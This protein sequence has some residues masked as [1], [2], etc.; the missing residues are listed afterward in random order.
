MKSKTVK[1][2][3]AGQSAETEQKSV[4]KLSLS[5]HPKLCGR[6]VQKKEPTDAGGRSSEL[7]GRFSDGCQVKQAAKMM[8]RHRSARNDAS[9][10]KG[11]CQGN[12]KDQ[13]SRNTGCIAN[14]SNVHQDF[15]AGYN[16]RTDGACLYRRTFDGTGE[17][18]S[19]CCGKCRY[20]LRV[21]G[22]RVWVCSNN[23]SDRCGFPTDY[24][25]QEVILVVIQR[26]E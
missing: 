9:A 4:K 2:T 13:D 20:H 17:Y 21:W 19:T 5:Y 15:M 22:C 12:K 10:Y 7:K 25:K 24:G 6:H 1:T 18:S 26:R 8:Q 3:K 23:E 11:Y 14:G 16:S